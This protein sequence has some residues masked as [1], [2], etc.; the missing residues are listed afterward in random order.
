MFYEIFEWLTRHLN[1]RLPIQRLLTEQESVSKVT[2]R[3]ILTSIDLT[4]AQGPE[5][6]PH[7]R[8]CPDKCT[9]IPSLGV[10][11]TNTS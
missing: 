2:L 3:R 7:R 9:S 8:P 11:T 5:Y 10:L 4:A 1:E 6:D